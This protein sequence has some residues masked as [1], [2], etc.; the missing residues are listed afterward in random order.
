MTARRWCLLLAIVCVAGLAH[1]APND[2]VVLADPDPELLRAVTTTLAP[3]RFE[4]VVDPEPPAN[5]GEAQ[6]RA[7]ERSARFVVWRRDGD[8][9]VF[10]RERGAAEH[11]EGRVGTLDPID[12]AAAA[13]T[14][15]TLMRLPPPGSSV[16]RPV[17]APGAT[18]RFQLGSAARFNA[19]ATGARFA[20]VATIRPWATGLG[21]GIAGDFGTA[22]DVE[23][24]GFRGSWSDLAL[25][26]VVSWTHEHATWRIEPFVAVGIV[27]SAVEGL[28]MMDV[29]ARTHLV[30]AVRGGVHGGWSWNRLSFGISLAVEGVTS[31]PTYTRP[32]AAV[33]IFEVP[34][35]AVSAGLF[36]AADFEL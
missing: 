5:T 24:S 27:R 32:P 7:E 16:A 9:V 22:A 20:A 17:E 6:K 13:L 21:F 11:R 15:K 30:G 3:W 18:L 36:A 26:A 23:Q 33:E 14:V 19:A 35:I 12:A 8:L 1:A 25:L 34:A 10:D 31:T 4:I 28:A 2:R 29:I